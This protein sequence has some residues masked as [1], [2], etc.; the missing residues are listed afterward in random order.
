M[1]KRLVLVW[2]LCLIV[3]SCTSQAASIPGADTTAP[4]ANIVE[5]VVMC[6]TWPDGKVHIPLINRYQRVSAAITYQNERGATEQIASVA[7][8]WSKRFRAKAGTFL[9][10]SGQM[11]GTDSFPS[12]ALDIRVEIK[13]NGVVVKQATSKGSFAVATASATP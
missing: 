6:P 3:T 12:I 1:M 7:I 10:I 8:P 11:M 5:Y 13:V 4:S 2:I 9:Y